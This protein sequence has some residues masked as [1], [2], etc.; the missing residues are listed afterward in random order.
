MQ[1]SRIIM[2]LLTAAS[3][4]AYGHAEQNKEADEKSIRDIVQSYQ[5]AYNKQDAAKLTSQWASDAIYINPVTGESAEGKEAIEKLFKEKFAQGKQRNLEVT[6]K[7]IE[8]PNPDEAIETGVLKVMIFDDQPPRQVAYRM[9]YAREN[10]K[11]LVKGLNEIE[12]LEAP[13]NFEQL[14]DLAWLV[15][16]WEDSDDNV[17]I[18]FDNQWDKYKNFITQHFK[19]K[20]HGQ[21]DF[22]GKQIIAWDPVK[23]V[24]RSWVFDSDGEFGEGTWKK[25]DKSWYATMRYTLSD[26]RVALSKNIF[27]PIDERRYTFASVEREVEGEILPDMNPVTVIKIEPEAP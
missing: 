25:V 7:N 19:M 6:I 10:G 14:K 24:I 18:V 12:L 23:K 2:T 26:G 4:S 8:F 21:D 11:W 27:T 15:G 1:L 20:I 22:E 9:R 16:R 17:Q 3:F 13:S 5:E